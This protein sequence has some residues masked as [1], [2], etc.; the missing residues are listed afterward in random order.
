MTPLKVWRTCLR[1]RPS[2]ERT[3]E[4]KCSVIV[5]LRGSRLGYSITEWFTAARFNGVLQTLGVDLMK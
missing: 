4:Y 3:L 1:Q 2:S 5:E